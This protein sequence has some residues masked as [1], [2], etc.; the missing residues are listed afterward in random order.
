MAIP[1]NANRTNLDQTQI[2]QRSFDETE[3]RIRVDAALSVDSA[4]IVVETNYL[5]DSMAIGDPVTNNILKI[6]NDGSID[7][8]ITG[9]ATITGDVTS[10]EAGLDSFQT[11][12]YAVNLSVLQVTPVPLANRSSITLRVDRD[13]IGAIY[14][15]ATNTVSTTTGYPLFAGDTLSMDLTPSNAIFAVSDTIGQI[16]AVLEI[17]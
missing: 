8:N 12:Q 6:N 16:L 1:T 14:I 5:T 11:N 17:A 2:F 9:S 7:A 3:D 13:N 15:G 10:H 4:T